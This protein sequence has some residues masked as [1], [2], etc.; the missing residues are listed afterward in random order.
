VISDFHTN[1]G[2]LQRAAFQINK[3]HQKIIQSALLVF[4]KGGIGIGKSIGIGFLSCIGIGIVKSTIQVLV[5]V[6]VLLRAPPKYWY[7]Y[8]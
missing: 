5:L 3:L 4:K 1:F 2:T 7:W 6:L 8:C